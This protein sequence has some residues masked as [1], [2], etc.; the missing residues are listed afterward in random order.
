[1]PVRELAR[2]RRHRDA[3]GQAIPVPR[4]RTPEQAE[5]A[6]QTDQT[7]QTDQAQGQE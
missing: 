7:D 1:V 6:D 4:K 2:G 3:A 5:Q